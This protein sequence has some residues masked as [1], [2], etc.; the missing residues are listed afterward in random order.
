[1]ATS[2]VTGPTAGIGLAFAEQLAARGDDLVLVARDSARLEAL[3]AR[4]RATHGV[5]VEVLVADLTDRDDL[6]RVE[7][8]L[9]EDARP[10]E[11][12]VNNAGFG[13]KGRFL[14]NS[15]DE[16][17][18]MLEVLTV[19]VLRLSHAALG[20]MVE[21]GSGG[22]INVSSVAAFLPRGTYG[23][24]KAWVTSFTEWAAHEYADRGV[25][26]MALCPGF[27]RTEFHERMGVQADSA[28]E[29]MWLEADR[30]V[31]D[32]LADFER[33]AVLSVPSLQY[34]AIAT[35]S[36]L[37]PTSLLIRLQSLGRR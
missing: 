36:R 35:V 18:A 16:E 3:A 5:E 15:A 13:L 34:K 11:L 19:A 22:V 23:A 8:R 12:L 26:L 25:R 17:T 24:A 37:V 10:V 21:R 27:V 28:P 33:G 30:L 32:A 20:P 9:A 6:A 2:L 1:M 4:L 29:F 31:A 7:Q 14:D